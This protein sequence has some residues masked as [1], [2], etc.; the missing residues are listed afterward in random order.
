MKMANESS[1]NGDKFEHIALGSWRSGNPINNE[2][3]E[4]LFGV[5]NF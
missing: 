2:K 3:T 1:Y 4:I 5:P